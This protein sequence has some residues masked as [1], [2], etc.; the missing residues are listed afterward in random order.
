MH[1]HELCVVTKE[2][3]EG[4]EKHTRGW[5]ARAAKHP[6]PDDAIDFRRSYAKYADAGTET[7]YRVRYMLG[8]T[9][10]TATIMH[11]GREH[12]LEAI[13]KL[14]PSHAYT[15]SPIPISQIFGRCHELSEREQHSREEH[16]EP[17]VSKIE[18]GDFDQLA[19]G[20]ELQAFDD[21]KLKRG[22]SW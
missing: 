14:D 2:L 4:F 20:W 12:Q 18:T 3:R 21:R 8:S 10:R 9:D 13:F 19:S 7:F 22:N 11:E 1:V 5:W 16:W 15:P 17:F 6:I